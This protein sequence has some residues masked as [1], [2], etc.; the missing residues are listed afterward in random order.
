MSNL[1]FLDFTGW[2]LDLLR[3]IL[4]L[5]TRTKVFPESPEALKLRPDFAQAANKLKGAEIRGEQLVVNDS[6]ENTWRRVGLSLDRAGL[7]ITDRNLS[8]RVYY[9][10]PN[11]DDRGLFK[12]S[13]GKLKETYQVRFT[14]I[15]ANQTQ[16]SF[17]DKNGQPYS[18]QGLA[19]VLKNL[20]NSLQ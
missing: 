4:Y 10:T 5:G 8:Q 14:S 3:R 12:K 2:T 17:A 19:R 16:V 7:S 11:P 9:V 1:S 20:K 6:M 15:S 18:D 13:F